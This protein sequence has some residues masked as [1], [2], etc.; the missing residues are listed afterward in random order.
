MSETI[1][2]VRVYGIC[3]SDAAVLVTDEIRYGKMITK[4]PG[5]GLQF[6]EGTIECLKRECL[7]EFNQRIDVTEHFYT[8]DFFQRSAFNTQ[9][10]II[11]IYYLISIAEPEKIQATQKPF[12]FPEHKEEAQIFR[13]IPLSN[14][15]ETD[16]TFPIEKKVAELLKIK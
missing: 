15:S 16:F 2:N 9:H 14:L 6:G 12:D 5:G 10:Q 4:F 7:E 11:S 13:W 8:T 3:I 1:F